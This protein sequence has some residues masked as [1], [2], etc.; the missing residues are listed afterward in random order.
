M[1]LVLLTLHV[2][3]WLDTQGEVCTQ[4]AFLCCWLQY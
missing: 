2:V 3:D 4:F 1:K